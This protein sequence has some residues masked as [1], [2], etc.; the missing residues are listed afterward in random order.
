MES[1]ITWQQMSWILSQILCSWIRVHEHPA[2]K[3][4]L[5]DRECWGLL[6]VSDLSAYTAATG[7]AAPS[8]ASAG[9]RPASTVGA[10]KAAKRGRQKV[11]LALLS[12]SGKSA[13]A[14]FC[15]RRSS[16]P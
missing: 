6:Q 11:P 5:A 12:A 16:I 15:T 8:T 3:Q 14:P 2:C 13:V 1:R 10:R 4:L 7:T 9:G